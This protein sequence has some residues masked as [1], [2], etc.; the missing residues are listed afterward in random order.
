QE[1][2]QHVDH[3]RDV[4]VGVGLRHRGLENRLGA[5]MLMDRH[6]SPPCIL[7]RVSVIRPMSSMPACR[8]SSI[9]SMTALYGA[10]SSALMM[11]ILSDLSSRTSLIRLSICPLATGLPF[12]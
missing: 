3:R 8:S 10:S 2:E 5:V 11:T 4:H 7:R 9:V 12:T 1:H 6:Y